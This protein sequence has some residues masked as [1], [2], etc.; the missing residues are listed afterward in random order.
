M[1]A[2]MREPARSPRVAVGAGVAM[3]LFVAAIAALFCLA[4]VTVN[5]A[6]NNVT[7]ADPWIAAGFGAATYLGVYFLLF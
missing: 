4:V 5:F 2:P 1:N 3:L 6:L 7:D